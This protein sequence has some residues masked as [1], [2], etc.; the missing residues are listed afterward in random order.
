MMRHR[1]LAAAAALACVGGCVTDWEVDRFAAP[2]ADVAALRTFAWQPGQ[3]GTPAEVPAPVAAQIEARLR[4][5]VTQELVRKGYAEV[6]DR[7]AAEMIVTYQ[8]AG[9]RRTVV[10]EQQRVGAPSPNDVLSPSRTP[11]PP[12]SE[13]PREQTIRSGSVILFIE[14][15]ASGRLL[16]RGLIQADTRTG[17]T[18]AGIRTLERMAREIVA[19]VP[20]RRQP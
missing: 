16:W 18:E 8:V 5:V 4:A 11:P 9:S 14:D 6:P 7:S 2:E 1:W 15:P 19:T 12:L 10:S 13:L 17:S 3:L 20:A